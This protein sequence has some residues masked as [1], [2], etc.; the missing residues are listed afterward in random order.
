MS[1]TVDHADQWVGRARELSP[2]FAARAAG[3]DRE[4][5]FPTEDFDDLQSAG[6]LATAVPVAF[7]GAGISMS[8]G[9]PLTQWRVTTEVAKGDLSLGRC[10]EGHVNAVDLINAHGTADQRARYLSAVASGDCR[11]VIWGSEP[12][13]KEVKDFNLKIGN[14]T[15]AEP[16]PGGWRISGIK[17]FATSAGAGAATHALIIALLPDD[18]REL[19]EQ[20]HLF[21]VDLDQPGVHVDPDWWHVLGMRA[22]VSHMVKLDGVMVP[23]HGRL[24]TIKTY[25]DQF[26]QARFIPH[27]TASFLGASQAALDFSVGYLSERGKADDPY[28]QHHAARMKIGIELMQGYLERTAAGWT[29]GR[30]AEA[31]VMSNICRAIGEEQAEAVLHAAIR[32]CGASALLEKYPL[33]RIFR[34]LATYVRHESIDRILGTI[35][36]ACLGLSYD[37]NW[38]N[39]AAR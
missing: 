26:W 22:T 29:S 21:I 28:V 24:M 30:V 13:R 32:A 31:A 33:E 17:G 5:R 11:F 20:Q 14:Q 18:S 36:R 10:Y 9:D 7:G 16:V 15:V 37:A 25:L 23:E 4:I 38:S 2:R 19:A 12:V 35:G 39:P 8:N 6:L 1:V 27:F 34:D 3:Y